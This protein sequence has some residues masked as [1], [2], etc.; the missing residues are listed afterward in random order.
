MNMK[1]NEQ[2]MAMQG[3]AWSRENLCAEIARLRAENERLR[4][5]HSNTEKAAQYFRARIEVLEGAEGV[6]VEEGAEVEEEE[7]DVE[8]DKK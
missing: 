3:D 2:R 8:E 1:S 7:V 4:T 5:A 6:E